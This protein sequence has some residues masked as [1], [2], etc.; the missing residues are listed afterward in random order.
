MPR[1]F[2]ISLISLLLSVSMASQASFFKTDTTETTSTTLATTATTTELLIQLIAKL[3]D[4]I[5]LMADRILL[6]AD[7]IAEM[8]S[9]IVATE[10]LMTE[11]TL[12]MVES[13]TAM[14]NLLASNT[15]SNTAVMLLTPWGENVSAYTLP[16]IQISDNATQYLLHVS[17]T[18]VM[19]NRHL[20]LLVNDS[21]D[22]NTVW[23]QALTMAVEGQLYIAVQSVNG[24]AVSAISNSVL[25]NLN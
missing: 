15:A 3:S 19:D 20:S 10:Q 25:L 21:T 13:T 16:T 8:S 17:A 2:S 24:D 11:T 5:G 1:F 18:G 4:D 12:S 7:E 6:M 9:R 22:L 23:Q 14:N